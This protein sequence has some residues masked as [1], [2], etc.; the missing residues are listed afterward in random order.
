MIG[1]LVEFN[2]IMESLQTKMEETTG[3]VPAILAVATTLRN[4]LVKRSVLVDIEVVDKIGEY[5][6]E[7]ER[8]LASLQATPA[9][10]LMGRP[11]VKMMTGLVDLLSSFGQEQRK[12]VVGKTPARQARLVE[13]FKTPQPEEV[14]DPGDEMDCLMQDRSLSERL[15]GQEK[16]TVATPVARPAFPRFQSLNDFTEGS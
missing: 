1:N 5:A 4:W 8:R 14:L 10:G 3:A 11:A 13:S 15:G 7:V 2:R 16:E 9:R 6:G 12:V